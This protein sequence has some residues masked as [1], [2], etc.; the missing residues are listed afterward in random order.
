MENITAKLLRSHETRT[1]KEEQKDCKICGKHKE[2]T[3][4]HHVLPL[5]D[6]AKWLNLGYLE[7]INISCVWLCPNCHSYIDKIMKGH[8]M[9]LAIKVFSDDEYKNLLEVL[10]MRDDLESALYKKIMQ[11]VGETT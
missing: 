1:S 11:E 5:K 6:A 8:N 10:K 4:L 9:Y 3:H 2:I 7:E